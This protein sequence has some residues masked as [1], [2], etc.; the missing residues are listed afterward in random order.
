VTARGRRKTSYRPRL[1]RSVRPNTKKKPEEGI[2][3]QYRK[4]QTLIN[5]NSSSNNNNIAMIPENN[6]K[7]LRTSLRSSF[8]G[9]INESEWN[10]EAYAEKS[11]R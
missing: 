10:H 3:Q 5:N 7:V 8:H 4:S 6:V 1:L 9:N 2:N 11:K